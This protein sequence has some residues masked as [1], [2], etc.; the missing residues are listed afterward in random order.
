MWKN[1][2]AHK[3]TKASS[4]LLSALVR[5]SLCKEGVGCQVRRVGVWLLMCVC[6][7]LETAGEN[8]LS[9]EVTEKRNLGYD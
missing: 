5:E 7:R 4:T 8:L 2:E 3:E 9:G 1:E 6:V